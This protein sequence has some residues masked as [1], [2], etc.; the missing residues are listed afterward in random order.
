[1]LDTNTAQTNLTSHPDSV[2]GTPDIGFE[3]HRAH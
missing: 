1:V 2:N 3:S